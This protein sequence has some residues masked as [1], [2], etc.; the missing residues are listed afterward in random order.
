MKF[1]FN[2]IALM[3][4]VF[5]LTS[6]GGGQTGIDE[7]SVIETEPENNA[8]SVDINTIISVQV[9]SSIDLVSIIPEKI[10]LS[11]FISGLDVEGD[12]TIEDDKIIFAP[13]NPLRS[14]ADYRL[15]VSRDFSA[16]VDEHLARDYSLSFKT[17][18]GNDQQSPSIESVIPADK[19]VGVVVN[20][21]IS[22]TFDEPIKATSV[23][24]FEL[25]E[26]DQSSG[27]VGQ[28]IEGILSP[29]S[30]IVTFSP[31]TVNSNELNQN[32]EYEVKLSGITD[33]AGNQM[34][35]YS[36]RFTTGGEDAI[37][38][39]APIVQQV[40][41]LNDSIDIPIT[42]GINATFSEDMDASTLTNKQFTLTNL[43]T[44]NLVIGA[45]QYSNRVATF[46]IAEN[47]ELLTSGAEFEAKIENAKD[48]A[49][50]VLET[51][52]WKFTTNSSDQ[53]A[54]H[55]VGDAIV[56]QAINK[57]GSDF[58]PEIKIGFS[59][60]IYTAS[61]NPG[62]VKLS[63]GDIGELKFFD[64][65]TIIFKP[66]QVLEEK[67][68]Y[69]L[70]VTTAI[71]DE[72]LKPLA[73]EYR[74]DFTTGDVTPPVVKIQVNRDTAETPA[75]GSVD[76]GRDDVI[77]VTFSEQLDEENVQQYLTVKAGEK[78]ISGDIS[79]VN[80]NEIKF[81][82]SE[83]YPENTDIAVFIN[84]SIRDLA[85]NQFIE[86]LDTNWT[87]RTGDF[88]APSILFTSPAK[89]Q[90]NVIV[91]SEIV[92]VFG[93]DELIE[94]STVNVDTFSLEKS[95]DKDIWEFVD[96]TY[97]T[98]GNVITLLPLVA[99]DEEA[100]YRVVVKDTITDLVGHSLGNITTWNFT[101][102]DFTSPKIDEFSPENLATDVVQLEPISVQF[103]EDMNS[104]TT[105]AAFSID[106][107]VQGSLSVVG[108]TMTFTPSEKMIE[109]QT[110]TVT[111]ASTAE[112]QSVNKNSLNVPISWMFTIGDFTPPVVVENTPLVD[113]VNIDTDQIISVQFSEDMDAAATVA[114]FNISPAT[115]GTPVVEGNVL[116][117][118]PATNWI[119][120]ELYTVS[121]ANT[122]KD[123]N[124][125]ALAAYS[126]DFRV[127][128]FTDPTIN[129]TSPI[130]GTTDNAKD[131]I[132][133]VVFSE[134]MDPVTANA[135][136]ISPAVAGDVVVVGDTLTFTAAETLKELHVYSFTINTT[137]EDQNGNTLASPQNINFRVGDFTPPET[138]LLSPLD[139]PQKK[140]ATNANVIAFFD[141]DISPTT[142]NV[143][144][145]IVKDE[146]GNAVVGLPEVI[147]EQVK[148]NPV[149]DWDEETKYSVQIT[150]DVKDLANNSLSA[151]VLW[152]FT[153]G[154]FTGPEVNSSTPN[155]NA[156][157]ITQRAPV[158][159][160]FS[161]AMDA[162]STAAAFNI[163][164]NVAGNP[165]V[166]SGNIL[167][168]TP[169]ADM[170]EQETYT[171]TVGAGAKDQNDNNLATAFSSSFT[172]GDFTAPTV[173]SSTPNNGATGI[174]QRAPISVVFSEAMDATATASAF[175]I[176]PNVA[177]NPPV[178]SGKDRK[179]VV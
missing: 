84:S 132:I 89:D 131:G 174:T 70:V 140:V 93:A 162:T 172:I 141:E 9:S 177:G 156:T 4:L 1:R 68:T 82:P 12:I 123:A 98:E 53:A 58:Q 67:T 86:N 52:Q 46:Q 18:L 7:F 149:S 81:V 165:P 8:T 155:N 88:F 111:V 33:D 20:A 147:G 13:A 110:Y 49:G 136:E 57:S 27:Q 6:C 137:A 77:S 152:T 55:V 124:G 48:L 146:A 36:W 95:I 38:S 10:T 157:G 17:K 135:F 45:V 64:E 112:D 169:A 85:K 42:R 176:S 31:I 159:V 103:D 87:F 80:G 125:V 41:P 94:E 30:N 170:T 54:P 109:L 171:V 128:D 151:D 120:Q 139:D 126:W 145:F 115:A 166:V 69:T 76:Q 138:I 72:D 19:T 91:E 100:S 161:E 21:G 37:D 56:P 29:T 50:N 61:V 113:S 11:D 175:N 173:N 160:V 119:E 101:V 75:D 2:I 167:T 26:V 158:S 73:E 144:S 168:F 130:N 154:D 60:A 40:K 14:N 163:S 107:Q 24:G 148:F 66:S 108:N 99:L 47:N 122:A 153:T 28:K 16:N 121:I 78:I 102:G 3:L 179:S 15:R 178:V 116:T 114:A 74:F 143:N 92:V 51:Y 71:L 39:E 127:G 23:T 133:K 97:K 44:G 34:E 65:K 79:I 118:D 63:N 96:A 43:T 105:Q 164:P 59:E 83:V 22:V 106:P 117:F 104:A 5:V 25:Y 150:T 129:S 35:D 142:V 90:L 62:S 134:P 32:T